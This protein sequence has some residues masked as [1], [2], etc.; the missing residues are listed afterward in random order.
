MYKTSK[1]NINSN[2]EPKVLLINYLRLLILVYFIQKKRQ[3]RIKI[4]YYFIKLKFNEIKQINLLFKLFT[5]A[6]N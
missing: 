2:Y 6:I 3:K 5:V 4:R 1:K